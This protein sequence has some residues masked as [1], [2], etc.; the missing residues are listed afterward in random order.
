MAG[1]RTIA[2][3]LAAI[4]FEDQRFRITMPYRSSPKTQITVQMPSMYQMT[5]AAEATTAR[6]RSASYGFDRTLD[7]VDQPVEVFVQDVL[8][9]KAKK[10]WLQTLA[11]L[12]SSRNR[13][14]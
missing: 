6:P 4:D 10:D 1:I 5:N 11:V 14:T 7:P 12:K 13:L 2:R 3:T 8:L 9:V